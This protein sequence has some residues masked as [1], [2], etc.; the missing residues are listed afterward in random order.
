[1][2]FKASNISRIQEKLRASEAFGPCPGT[3]TEKK[4]NKV[5]NRIVS[6]L[7][8]HFDRSVGDLLRSMLQVN[9]KKRLRITAIEKNLESFIF[10][11]DENIKLH[12]RLQG[13]N[14]HDSDSIDEYDPFEIDVDDGIDDFWKD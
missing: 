6:K 10:N 14:S 9:E 13:S 1:M 4:L 3:L 2:L 5:T 12:C 11:I 7:E 8:P